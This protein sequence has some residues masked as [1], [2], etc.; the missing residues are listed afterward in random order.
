MFSAA[1]VIA[2]TLEA[3]GEELIRR[4]GVDE[5]FE[6][7]AFI[8]RGPDGGLSRI[9]WPGG[10][11]FRRARWRGVIPPNAVAVMHTHPNRMPR[12]SDHDIAESK[13]IGLPFY[14]VTRTTL[15]RVDPDRTVSCTLTKS[16]PKLRRV[17]ATADHRLAAALEVNPE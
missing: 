3:I 15:C 6:T 16:R 14:V 12:P 1:F 8:V 17:A 11:L 4:N 9:F 5:D 2:L 7:A 10:H 13:R